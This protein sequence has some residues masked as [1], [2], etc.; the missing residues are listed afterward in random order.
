MLTIHGTVPSPFARKVRC[1]LDE[2]GVDYQSEQLIP[3]PKTPELLALNPRG[4]IP[5]LQDGDLVLPD[6]SVMCAYIERLHPEPAFYPRDPAQFGRALWLEEYSDTTLSAA[7]GAVFFERFVKKVLMQAEP[8]EERVQE[9]LANELPNA[10]EVLETEIGD[11][12]HL[13]GGA[14]SIA[15]AA[16]CSQLVNLQHGGEPLDAERWPNLARYLATNLARPAFKAIL[17]EEGLA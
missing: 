7:V 9:A 14:F 13:V 10:L 15:D 16:V 3:F 1:M 5:I 2:K 11:R 8:D 12:D 4:Q 17:A 6:S